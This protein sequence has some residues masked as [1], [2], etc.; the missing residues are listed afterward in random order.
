MLLLLHDPRAAGNGFAPLP[1]HDH[2]RVRTVELPEG[3]A[4]LFHPDAHTA[5]VMLELDPDALGVELPSPAY[6][7]Y[8]AGRTLSAALARLFP[9]GAWPGG[10][11]PRPIEARLWVVWS[12][13]SDVLLGRLFGPLGY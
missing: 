11:A 9:A 8:A 6:G 7:G 5:A 10:E 1:D 4:S 3:R 12:P 2:A 13:G